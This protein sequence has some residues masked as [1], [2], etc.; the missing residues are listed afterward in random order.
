MIR[1]SCVAFVTT[2]TQ[3]F[4]QMLCNQAGTAGECMFRPDELPLTFEDCAENQN[5][6]NAPNAHDQNDF[7]SYK[8]CCM[9]ITIGL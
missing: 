1:P 4:G 9:H 2:P 8:F 5:K 3:A 7:R 6:R